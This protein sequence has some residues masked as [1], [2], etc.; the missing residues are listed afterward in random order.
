M[1]TPPLIYHRETFNLVGQTPTLQNADDLFPKI[2]NAY[3]VQ[4]PASVKE[5]YSI[6]ESVDLML[7]YSNMDKSLS[8]SEI[9]DERDEWLQAKWY[10]I[11]DRTPTEYPTIPFLFEN[12][13][14]F[15]A[16]LLMD[17]SDDPP[18]ITWDDDMK[19]KRWNEHFSEFVLA[20]IWRYLHRFSQSQSHLYAYDDTFT[21][22][23]VSFLYQ[24]FKF[25]EPLYTP[26]KIYTFQRDD[27]RIQVW[28]RGKYQTN[29]WI[30]ANTATSLMDVT[31]TIWNLGTLCQSLCAGN[32]KGG[33]SV[34]EKLRPDISRYWEDQRY[35][36]PI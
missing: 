31:Y 17:G 22:E 26:S 12:Q 18:V 10:E 34:L 24:N 23:N 35:K 33:R 16:C 7:H 4:L 6:K 5:W 21:E 32:N 20:W 15:V 28:D 27:Q 36:K 8:L 9:L 3:N 2:E 29:Y 13:G 25:Q 19:W 1:T 11:G 30:T 14:I